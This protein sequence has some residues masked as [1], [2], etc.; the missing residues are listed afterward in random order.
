M[1]KFFLCM[2]LGLFPLVIFA[3]DI[4]LADNS[5]VTLQ[6]QDEQ[7]VTTNTA[8]VIV[9]IDATLDKLGLLQAREEVLKN[10]TQLAKT[11]WHLT[12]FSQMPN[13]SGLEQLHISAQARIPEASLAGLRDQAKA[14]SK[15]GLT[16]RILAINFVPSLTEI[17]NAKALLRTAFYIAAQDE[18]ARLNKAYP[19]QTYTIHSINFN[20]GPPPVPMNAYVA[21][22]GD[23]MSKP[24]SAATVLAVST[25]IQ[26]TAN[27]E[28]TANNTIDNLPV[29]KP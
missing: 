28:L 3:K 29:A 22:A 11:D 20:D 15:P 12:E 19:K 18:V 14:L 10:L 21:L 1:K 16:F 13:E 24:K 6:L 26:M 23:G 9:G 25:K 7:W 2:V 4:N 27:V 5:T 17:E 8:E